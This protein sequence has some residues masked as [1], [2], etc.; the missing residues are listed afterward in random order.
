MMNQSTEMERNSVEIR[1]L[2]RPEWA[3]KS[4]DNAFGIDVKVL[5]QNE[6]LLIAQFCQNPLMSEFV[7][8]LICS[9]YQKFNE[10][11]IDGALALMLPDVEWANGMEGGC[12]FGT[13]AVRSYWIRQWAAF[14]SNVTPKSIAK[15]GQDHIVEVH[16]E[17]KSLTGELI[18]DTIV[19]HAFRLRDGKIASMK[20]RTDE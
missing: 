16:Q 15:D 5:L 9:V 18:S 19:F 3:S 14:S 6:R 10:H 13:D 7:S 8:K 17:V 12:V 1:P 20:I 2:P 11:D 4:N